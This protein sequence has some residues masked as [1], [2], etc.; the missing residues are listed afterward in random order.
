VLTM[1]LW[2]GHEQPVTT[3]LGRIGSHGSFHDAL[4]SAID[5]VSRITGAD[6]IRNVGAYASTP[7]QL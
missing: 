3:N 2:T 6:G 5:A 4:A 1:I 7:L